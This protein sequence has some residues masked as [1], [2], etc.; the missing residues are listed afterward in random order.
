MMRGRGFSLIESVV[1][2]VAIGIMMPPTMLLL[3]QTERQR[4]ERA[5]ASRAT[6]FAQAAIE[7]VLADT[8]AGSG[9]PGYRGVG[10][11]G[12]AEVLSER[13][14]RVR[15]LYEPIGLD[16]EIEVGA[17]RDREGGAVEAGEAGFR[18]I[19]VT[20]TYPGGGGVPRS[21]QLACVTTGFGS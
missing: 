20:V 3:S 18:D 17:E 7:T 12:Y 14:V 11:A 13:L 8:Y 21:V 6:A 1:V 4:E 9:A 2:V 15:Q 16:L 19:T 10:E 5:M